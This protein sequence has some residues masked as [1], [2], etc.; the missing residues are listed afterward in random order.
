MPDF[1]V[2]H[3]CW[4]PKEVNALTTHLDSKQR[5]LDSAWPE[6]AC[7][8]SAGYDAAETLRHSFT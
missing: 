3:A 4:Y 2:V 5:I 1:R 6:L 7:S 8:G